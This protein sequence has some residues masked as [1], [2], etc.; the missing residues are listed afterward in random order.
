MFTGGESTPV[1][2]D[3]QGNGALAMA[4]KLDKVSLGQPIEVARAKVRREAS[5]GVCE[6]SVKDILGPLCPSVGERLAGA[7]DP[8]GFDIVIGQIAPIFG[9]TAQSG[10]FARVVVDVVLPLFGESPQA[11]GFA[12]VSVSALEPRREG[13]AFAQASPPTV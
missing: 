7:P 4:A 6:T 9:E 13:A 5:G 10:G 11:I 8:V 3:R 2:R 1:A 12:G